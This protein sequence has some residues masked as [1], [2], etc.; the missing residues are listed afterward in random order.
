MT[1]HWGNI[2]SG[3]ESNFQKGAAMDIGSYNDGS[4]MHYGSDAFS[5]NGQPTITK[6]GGGQ[7]TG[8][9]TGLANSDILGLRAL[10]TDPGS[11][12]DLASNEMH[13]EGR[14]AVVRYRPRRNATADT[15][16]GSVRG[17]CRSWCSAASG[18]L[19]RGRRS[20][21]LRPLA[22]VR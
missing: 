8:Q 2:Q 6:V 11:G 22:A 3:K 20:L 17:C 18:S 14:C 9:R 5:A 19:R 7:I 15:C 21:R 10:F 16:R 13:D 4:I 12:D 1:I